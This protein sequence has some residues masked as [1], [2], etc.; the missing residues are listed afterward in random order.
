MKR[1][2][3]LIGGAIL[4]TINTLSAQGLK[5]ENVK[6]KLRIE[7]GLTLSENLGCGLFVKRE[8][9]N[10]T[11]LRLDLGRST[12]SR[13]PYFE[14]NLSSNIGFGIEHVV[15][16]IDRFSFYHGA[17]VNYSFEQIGNTWSDVYKVR[18]MSIGYRLGFKYDVSKRM[19]IGAEINPQIGLSKVFYN[20]Q[21]SIKGIHNT[22][23][24][25]NMGFK[26]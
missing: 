23:I 12:F 21:N 17:N 16:I 25:V 19:V 1:F 15:P 5:V 2:L 20:N 24:S 6:P 14:F 22:P 7:F 10:N 9:K 3:W 26:F 4:L 8:I 11:F 13:S 18:S